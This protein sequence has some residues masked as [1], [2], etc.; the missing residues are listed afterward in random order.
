MIARF[1]LS[2]FAT[3]PA[4]L[5]T[6][7]LVNLF[8]P[9]NLPSMAVRPLWL[10]WT[11]LGGWLAM[12]VLLALVQPVV[13]MWRAA[14]FFTGVLLVLAAP[15]GVQLGVAQRVGFAV[16]LSVLGAGCIVLALAIGEHRV[17]RSKRSRRNSAEGIAVTARSA[18]YLRSLLFW[19]AAGLF[20]EAFR[21]AHIVNVEPLRGSGMV[22]MVVALFLLLPAATLRGWLPRSAATLLTCAGV[23]Y[24]VMA[25]KSGLMQWWGGALL[26]FG[27]SLAVLRQPSLQDDACRE[28]EDAEG[29][30]A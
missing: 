21:L 5:V 9:E 8:P 1:F 3:L 6:L 2:L 15:C 7:A 26:S 20:V 18:G 17:R 29:E 10:V 14:L 23:V 19:L 16:A 22:G 13:A 28:D 25:I 11:L 27:L 24:V 4:A 30:A 12:S